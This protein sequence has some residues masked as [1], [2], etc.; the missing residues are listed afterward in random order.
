MARRYRLPLS[1]YSA[2]RYQ[3]TRF[4]MRAWKKWQ[5]GVNGK[6]ARRLLGKAL[7]VPVDL[8]TVPREEKT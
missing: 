4:S 3:A 7:A 2:S 8:E 5:P 1:V 6:S